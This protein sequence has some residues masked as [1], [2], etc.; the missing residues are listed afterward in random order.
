MYKALTNQL[1]KEIRQ[2][3]YSNWRRLVHNLTSDQS[4]AHNKGLQTLSWQSQKYAGA[5]QDYPHLPD[6]RRFPDSL[7]TVDNEKKAKILVGKF[8][9]TTDN[10]NL[11]NITNEEQSERRLVNVSPNISP[12][13]ICELARKFPNNKAPSSNK[14]PNEILKIAAPVIA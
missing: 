8:F 13:E 10:V 6:L 14:I 11:S 3:S 5:P 9:S 7:L 12:E 2:T 1:Q 4:K